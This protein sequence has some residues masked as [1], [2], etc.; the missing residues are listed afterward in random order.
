MVQALN[1]V[2]VHRLI[3]LIP[4]VLAVIFGIGWARAKRDVVR[5]ERDLDKVRRR[6]V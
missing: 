5:L 1:I 2:C 4:V 6:M 3:F